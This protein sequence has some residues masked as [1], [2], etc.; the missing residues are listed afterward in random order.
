MQV[1]FVVGVMKF[2]LVVVVRNWLCGGLRRGGCVEGSGGIE[3]LW[4]FWCRCHVVL[5]NGA[6]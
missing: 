1:V 3:W 2:V 4:R 5:A 6:S